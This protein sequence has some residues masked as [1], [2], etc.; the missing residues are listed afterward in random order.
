MRAENKRGQGLALAGLI[1]QAT[2]AGLICAA[3]LTTGS[4]PA[5]MVFLLMMGGL[6]VW[7][8]TA[9]LFYCRHLAQVE[10]L[11]M[12]ELASK[13]GRSA[14]FGEEITEMRLAQRR[15]AWMDRF[16]SPSVTLLTAGYSLLVALMLGRGLLTGRLNL[17]IEGD[18]L[19]WGGACLVAAFLLFLT[20]R[21]AIGM[22]KDLRW[23]LLRAGGSFMSLAALACAMLA[24]SFAMAHF[25]HGWGIK[26]LAYIIPAGMAVLGIE[27][28]LN[29]ILDFY[30]PRVAGME[31]R[32]SFDSRL[33]NLLSEPGSVAHSIAEALNYQ[34]GFEV[35]KTWFYQLVQKTFVPLIL[36]GLL[37]VVMMSAIV[38]VNPGQQAV[39][40]T[41][42]RVPEVTQKPLPE[43]IHFKLPW[44][45][46]TADVVD[47]SRIR[48]LTAGVTTE[49][50][51]DADEE[52]NGVKLYLWSQ[53]HGSVREQN[54][55]VARGTV[56][57]DS[58]S[59]HPA[60]AATET[61]A[62]ASASGP[63]S[64]PASA[65]AATDEKDRKVPVSLMRIVM[66]V[67][68]RVKDLYAFQYGA[69][70]TQA[71]LEEMVN[72]HLTRYAASH[73]L[74]TLMAAERQEA[75]QALAREIQADA[76]RHNLGVELVLLA[77][78]DIHPPAEAAAAFEDVIKAGRE[79]QG[80]LFVAQKTAATRLS[81][82]AGSPEKAEALAKAIR[83]QQQLENSSA[84]K[85]QAD[86]AA[87]QA[88]TILRDA[89]GEAKKAI[90]EAITYRWDKLNS[91]WVRY[92]SFKQRLAAYRAAPNLYML[93][94]KLRVFSTA[95]GGARKYVLG[96]GRDQL[97]IWWNFQQQKSVTGGMT[98]GQ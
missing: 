15:S 23:R 37:S 19:V 53:E 35:S 64:G 71:L 66:D 2:L 39:V 26:L 52:V 31:Q 73:D 34:F 32:P 4:A 85:A 69:G 78:Q 57:N 49:Q 14:I 97:E 83:L 58:A 89:G 44:P 50:L 67:Q 8:I 70:D 79:A 3:W 29:F 68:Y 51:V 88:D 92:N 65:P 13:T 28:L 95:L 24:G 62:T 81:T 87:L 40:L 60:S 61:P 42:G 6:G 12:E 47:V 56:R 98:I 74:D 11:E 82:V 18:A 94:Q 1:L 10:M 84:P 38:L 90:N 48:T 7:L 80:A 76:D 45:I 93:N 86:Q 46:Q 9:V 25:G 55:V 77:M 20:S 17:A 41:W 36:F 59:T 63:A 16:I 91:Q 5:F 54:F 75:S 27:L 30:R 96:A 72:Q 22:S 43:G 21:Y 33:A